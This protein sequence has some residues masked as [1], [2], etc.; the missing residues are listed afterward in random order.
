MNASEATAVPLASAPAALA[1]GL[2]SA[3]ASQRLEQF[4]PNQ[5]APERP[6]KTVALLRKFWG[7]IPWMLE[8]AVVIDLVLGRWVEAGVIAALLVFNAA[9]GFVH[10][11][12]A[13]R[14]LALLRQR[15]HAGRLAATH[16]RARIDRLARVALHRE[17]FTGEDG[18]IDQ[19]HAIGQAGVGRNDVARAQAHHVVGHE[20]CSSF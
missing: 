16:E 19:N 17:R 4:G 9:I 13:Q 6:R 14:A 1:D 12:R 10:E 3:R 2:T 8:L 7:V 5:V 15:H 20:T 18:L 11:G